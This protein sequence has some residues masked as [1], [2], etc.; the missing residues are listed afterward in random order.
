MLSF[1]R[2]AGAGP[3]AQAD[4]RGAG[5]LTVA[6]SLECCPLFDCLHIDVAMTLANFLADVLVKVTFVFDY[7]TVFITWKH[8]VAP[9]K[10]V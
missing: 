6:P 4:V 3:S 9:I 10:I 5:R 8:I 1:I 7:K 2:L